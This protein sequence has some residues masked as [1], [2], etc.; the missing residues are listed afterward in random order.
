M[1]PPWVIGATG[2]FAAVSVIVLA[3]CRSNGAAGAE[4][5][6]REPLAFDEIES[7]TQSGMAER[8]LHVIRDQGAFD[9]L[10]RRHAGLN[11]PMPP[12]PAVDFE[13]F[14]VVAAFSGTQPTGGY[15]I[16]IEEVW[17]QPGKDG[18]PGQIVVRTTESVPDEDAMLTQATTVPFHMVQVERADGEGVMLVE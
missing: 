10:W 6:L 18:A 12:A 17:H 8:G 15:G 3:A 7:G 16:A 13:G 9:V 4:G 11:L 2:A 14:M 1:I 5:V